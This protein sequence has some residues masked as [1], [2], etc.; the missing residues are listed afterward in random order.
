M[1]VM[2]M[3]INEVI[4]MVMV[5]NEVMMMVISEVMVINEV[6]VMVINEVMVM[7]MSM[8]GM[9]WSQVIHLLVHTSRLCRRWWLL[10]MGISLCDWWR[11]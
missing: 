10:H 6:I 5:I 9:S 11:Q 2:V 8:A 1:M 7:V 3:E 4:V